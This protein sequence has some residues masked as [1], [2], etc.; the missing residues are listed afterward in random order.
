MTNEDFE[1]CFYHKNQIEEYHTR[2]DEL[3]NLRKIFSEQ[4]ERKYELFSKEQKKNYLNEKASAEEIIHI[5]SSEVFGY[6]Y[7]N[8]GYRKRINDLWKTEVRKF[9]VLESKKELEYIKEAF[10]KIIE[11]YQIKYE[12]YVNETKKII[13]EQIDTITNEQERELLNKYSDYMLSMKMF[14][15]LENANLL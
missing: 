14:N 1:A 15:R 6:V 9:E 10:D 13:K 12:R 11:N 7:D 3:D 4:L 8:N 2:Y 5:I